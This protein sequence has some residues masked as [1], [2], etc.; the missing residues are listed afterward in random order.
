MG[1]HLRAG[2]TVVIHGLHT[3]VQQPHSRHDGSRLRKSAPSVD[4]S[5]HPQMDAEAGPPKNTRKNTR[6]RPSKLGKRAGAWSVGCL[7]TSILAVRMRPGQGTFASR[8]FHDGLHTTDSSCVRNTTAALPRK[9]ADPRYP[10]TQP[11]NVL[12]R[13]RF[14]LHSPPLLPMR[15]NRT[16]SHRCQAV[17]DRS[18]CCRR[19]TELTDTP[20]PFRI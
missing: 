10:G 11:S 5:I 15:W 4:H 6:K 1:S 3:S 2:P 12:H 14:P 20:Q 17:Q 19:I 9:A 13:F 8:R 7:W 18:V 16:S